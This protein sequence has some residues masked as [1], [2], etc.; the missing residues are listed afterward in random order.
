MQRPDGYPTIDHDN[1]PTFWSNI[2]LPTPLEQADNL[3][4][5]MGD[6][7][8]ASAVWLET[9]VPAIAATI[10]LAV[11][12]EGND[13]GPLGWLQSQLDKDGLFRVQ[14]GSGTRWVVMLQMAGWKRYEELKKQRLESR[15][16]FMALKFGQPVLTRLVE[17]CVRP[18]VKRTGF[19]LRILTDPQAAGSIDNN[20]RAALLAA[21]FVIADLTHDSFG[22]YWEAGFGEGRGI[23]VIYTCEKAKWADSK[24]HF[25][26]N[27]MGTIIWDAD[28]LTKAQNDLAATIR[29]TLRAEAKQTGE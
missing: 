19:D 23:P 28:N 15:T 18:A 7:Q 4:L 13:S 11:T 24:T 10:G 8:A 6:N 14:G 12:P 29:A 1:M 20:L 17:E 22:A 21:R 3:I 2:R 25:D 9:T 5:W 27:H 16:A 26:T